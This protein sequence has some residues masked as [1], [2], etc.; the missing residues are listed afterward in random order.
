MSEVDIFQNANNTINDLLKDVD[1]EAIKNV[2]V[3]F[4][5]GLISSLVARSREIQKSLKC[6]DKYIY[7][8]MGVF[9]VMTSYYVTNSVVYS[10]GSLIPYTLVSLLPSSKGKGNKR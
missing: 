9:S 2:V 7:G 6:D 8:L 3:P 4:G 5:G 10:L 1:F